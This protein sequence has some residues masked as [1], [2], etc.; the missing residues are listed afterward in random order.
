VVTT[1]A[2]TAAA[3]TLGGEAA[4]PLAA[5]RARVAVLVAGGMPRAA[6]ARQ[7]ARET[8]LARRALYEHE[9]ER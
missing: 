3:A 5:G 8:G 6:A 4:G 2:G 7:V 1:A 9:E